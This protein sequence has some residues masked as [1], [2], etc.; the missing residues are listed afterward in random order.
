[1]FK[2]P[3]ENRFLK[4]LNKMMIKYIMIIRKETE[5]FVSLCNSTDITDM[6]VCV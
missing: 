6:G 1:M 5:M 3:Q 4:Y 2:L